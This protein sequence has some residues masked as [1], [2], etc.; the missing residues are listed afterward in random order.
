MQR[1]IPF[2]IFGCFFCW[3][4]SPFLVFFDLNKT[5]FFYRH[6]QFKSRFVLACFST[7]FFVFFTLVFCLNFGLALPLLLPVIFFCFLAVFTDFFSFLDLWFSARLP[8]DFTSNFCY[9]PVPYFDA[10][11][12]IPAQ[13]LTKKR[14][15]FHRLFESFF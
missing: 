10:C 8:S 5:C 4:R 14:G 9:F 6:N 12:C 3:S 2:A 11:F 13:N 1:L 7:C 15:G